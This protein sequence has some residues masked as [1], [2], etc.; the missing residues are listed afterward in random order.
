M[1]NALTPKAVRQNF[2]QAVIIFFLA[3]RFALV[4]RRYP[5]WM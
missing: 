4:W 2:H 1:I 5:F 3:L